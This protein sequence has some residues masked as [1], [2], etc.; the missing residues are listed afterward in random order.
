MNGA[1][2]MS[3]SWQL[4]NM[5]RWRRWPLSSPRKEPARSN[6]T[7]RESQREYGGL[8]DGVE[9]HTDKKQ[10]IGTAW[11]FGRWVLQT[12]LKAI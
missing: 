9:P 8:R 5:G 2:M 7:M 1:K 3:A 11:R 6:W 10:G 12:E 4:W